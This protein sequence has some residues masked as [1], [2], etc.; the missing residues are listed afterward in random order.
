M[1]E[2]DHI[3]I[4]DRHLGG[5]R[6]SDGRTFSRLGKS[7]MV[8]ALDDVENRRQIERIPFH[9]VENIHPEHEGFLAGSSPKTVYLKGGAAGLVP[10]IRMESSGCI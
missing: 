5:G 2:F 3:W 1:D 9:R 8:L 4:E 7:K 10:S 6:C